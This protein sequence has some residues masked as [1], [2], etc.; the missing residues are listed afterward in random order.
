MN[1]PSNRT[2]ALIVLAVITIG[3]AAAFILDGL[4]DGVSDEREVRI[5]VVVSGA[6]PD[7]AQAVSVGDR[8]YGQPAGMFVGEVLEATA[9]PT[10]RANPDSAGVLQASPDPLTRDITLV[11]VTQGRESPDFIAIGTQVVQV[12]MPFTVSSREY[13]V[14]GR[15]AQIDVR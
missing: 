5:T 6:H 8:V 3:G 15:I 14:R 10:M 1:P 11:I 13:Q 9:T 4:A 2:I 12:G 7:V